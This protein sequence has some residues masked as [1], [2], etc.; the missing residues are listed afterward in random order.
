MFTKHLFLEIE[1]FI[2]GKPSFDYGLVGHSLF[3]LRG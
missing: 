3:N 2:Q 1:H